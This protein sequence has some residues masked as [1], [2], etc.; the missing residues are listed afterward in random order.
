MSYPNITFLEPPIIVPSMYDVNTINSHL[1]QLS[2]DINTQNLRSKL[3]KTKRHR[4]NTKKT[5]TQT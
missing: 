3:E 5:V 2:V 1:D 4:L